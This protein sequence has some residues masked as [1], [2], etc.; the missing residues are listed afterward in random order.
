MGSRSVRDRK[1]IW[2]TEHNIEDSD[3]KANNNESKAVGKKHGYR[4]T[5]FALIME[6]SSKYINVVK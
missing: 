1:R 6:R 5:E 3:E 4:E 2:F